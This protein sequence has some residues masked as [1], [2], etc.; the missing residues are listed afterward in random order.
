[1]FWSLCLVA[2]V[3]RGVFGIRPEKTI[4]EH[5]GLGGLDAVLF[6]VAALLAT[7]VLVQWTF[8]LGHWASSPDPVPVP[9]PSGEAGQVRS[10]AW[11]YV[12]V[13]GLPQLLTLLERHPWAASVFGAAT[14][15]RLSATFVF[16]IRANAARNRR[17]IEMYRARRGSGIATAEASQG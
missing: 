6:V 3:H 14:A 13:I 15:S 2:L 7:V 12:G 11:A 17:E 10:F 16:G 9:D 1:M 8:L 4:A 5:P